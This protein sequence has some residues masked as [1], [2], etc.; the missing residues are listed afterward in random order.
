MCSSSMPT[1]FK[2][3]LF[4]GTLA[5]SLKNIAFHAVGVAKFGLR[6]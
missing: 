2:Q 4:P 5:V 3:M 1:V 6:H